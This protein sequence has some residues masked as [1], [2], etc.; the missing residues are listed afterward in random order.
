MVSCLEGGIEGS[1]HPSCP[2]TIAAIGDECVKVT[3]TQAAAIAGPHT[4]TIYR[5]IHE[6]KL[7]AIQPGGPTSPWYIRRVDLNTY[8]ATR[9][10]S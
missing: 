5:W 6:R 10:A 1:T 3:V 2:A 7:D 4:E 9:N 8:L